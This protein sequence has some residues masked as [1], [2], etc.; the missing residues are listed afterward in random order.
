MLKNT[1]LLAI[2]LST[3]SLLST[4]VFASDDEDDECNYTLTSASGEPGMAAVKIEDKELK[5]KLQNAVPNSLY[6]VWID[7]KNRE[8]N[9]LSPDYPLDKGA[10]GRGVAPAFATTAGVTAGMGLDANGIITDDDGDAMFKVELDYELLSD[11]ASPVVGGQLSMQGLNRVGGY[12]LR[13]YTVDP[14][15]A[16]SSQATDPDTGLPLIERSTVQGLTI[17]RHPDHITHGHTPG[18]GGVDHF[19]GFKGDFPSNCRS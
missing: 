7:F 10:L 6:T 3:V 2:T 17:V 1:I 11:G 14:N 15:S 19:P 12:W 18:V 4:N 16:A 8:T 5:I 13:V 9:S